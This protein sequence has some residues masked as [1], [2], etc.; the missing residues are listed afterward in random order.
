MTDIERRLL[1]ERVLSW[2]NVSQSY[3]ICEL[4]YKS[5]DD[6]D[7]YAFLTNVG[8]L[9]IGGRWYTYDEFIIDNYFITRIWNIPNI[10]LV[11]KFKDQHRPNVIRK[12]IEDNNLELI[13][14]K[15]PSEEKENENNINSIID[16][17]GLT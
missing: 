13:Y 16:K 5:A 12:L 9:V 11:H 1:N 6:P 10:S 15:N 14:F 17:Y 3:Y 7:V 2:L 4:Q 8:F